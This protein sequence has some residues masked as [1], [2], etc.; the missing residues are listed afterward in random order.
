M[1]LDLN[2]KG[3]YIQ[4]GPA[5]VVV[6][7]KKDGKN[8][9]E[10]EF[11]CSKFLKNILVEVSN[12]KEILKLKAFKININKK[13]I[14][15][16]V[17]KT[18]NASNLI[19]GKELTPMSAVAGAVSEILL[20]WISDRYEY[21]K[22]IVN[23]G[24][25]I[26]VDFKDSVKLLVGDNLKISV[27]SSSVKGIA[28]SGFGGR[29]LSKGIADYVTVFAESA[30]VADAAATYIA[31]SVYFK[32]NKIELCFAHELDKNTDLKGELVVK[33]IGNLDKTEIDRAVE[34]GIKTAEILVKQNKILGAIIKKQ[35]ILKYT[36]DIN[37][38]LKI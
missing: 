9:K 6:T 12:F 25:D 18:V 4:V 8:I 31:N 16:I 27:K 26:A 28:T 36:K 24:G 13:N 19:D 7:V 33:N 23:N 5:S 38:F 15:E 30:S 32:S 10:A 20:E 2:E 35:K 3:T 22:I 29:S 21:D 14:P 34:N 37:N 17:K 1:L 11:E